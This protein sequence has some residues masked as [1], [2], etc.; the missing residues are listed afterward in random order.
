MQ[1]TMTSH[2]LRTV[3]DKG[4]NLDDVRAVWKD[5][6]TRYPSHR[7]PGQHK[8]IGRGLC[9]ACDDATGRVITVFVDQVATPLRSDQ[10]N[11]RDAV[12][13]ANRNRMR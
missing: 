10:R 8:R 9:L 1:I 4:I 13:W 12:A 2:A 6:D 11:D 3:A 7:H 5:P